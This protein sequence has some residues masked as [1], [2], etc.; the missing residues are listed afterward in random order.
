MGH[1]RP[2]HKKQR[3]AYFRVQ[4]ANEELQTYLVYCSQYGVKR[5]ADKRAHESSRRQNL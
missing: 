3:V 1:L 2:Q 4:K 5:L